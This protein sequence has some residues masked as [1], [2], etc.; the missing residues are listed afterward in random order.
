MLIVAFFATTPAQ[1]PDMFLKYSINSFAHTNQIIWDIWSNTRN[2]ISGYLLPLFDWSIAP[3]PK[4]IGAFIQEEYQLSGS[5]QVFI[6]IINWRGSCEAGYRRENILS[7]DKFSYG[8]FYLL[9]ARVCLQ[10]MFYDTFLL[11]LPPR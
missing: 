3:K 6:E 9:N 8:K 1:N 7:N 2:S 5:Y 4:V 11:S 10:Q